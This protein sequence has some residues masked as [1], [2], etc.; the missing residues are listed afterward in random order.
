MSQFIT[1]MEKLT[2]AQRVARMVAAA[3]D[4]EDACHLLDDVYQVVRDEA[5]AMKAAEERFAKKPAK[6]VDITK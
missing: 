1:T 6:G 5:D 2:F 3:D 4:L